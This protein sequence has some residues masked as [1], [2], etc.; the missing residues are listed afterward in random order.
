MI[1]GEYEGNDNYNASTDNCK[2]VV[3]PAKSTVVVDNVTIN[4]GQT[5]NL[6]AEIKNATGI[7]F[8]VLKDGK[9]IISGENN[10][11]GISIA[12]LN[13]GNYTLRVTTKVD[14]N[15][16]SA[17]TESKI[18]VIPVIDLNIEKTVD[19]TKAD[20]GDIVTYVIIVTNNGPSNAT[21]VNVTEKLSSLVELYDVSGDGVYNNTTNIWFIGN[22]SKGDDAVLS[23]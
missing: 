11:N 16:S 5:V 8:E 17:T 9:T 18:N 4:H 10:T 15:H 2:V 12:N 19:Y 23:I 21:G 3:T 20:V 22:L 7:T 14:G 6:S 1:R 13:P